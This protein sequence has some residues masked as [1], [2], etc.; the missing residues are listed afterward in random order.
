MMSLV[1]EFAFKL[2]VN[3]LY[4][5]RHLWKKICDSIGFAGTFTHGPLMEHCLPFGKVST[6]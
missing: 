5:L 4:F 6:S 2:K 3:K 1:L